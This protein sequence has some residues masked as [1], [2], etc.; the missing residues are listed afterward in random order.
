MSPKELLIDRIS[1]QMMKKTLKIQIVREREFKVLQ[2]SVRCWQ[3]L[4]L[5]LLIAAPSFSLLPAPIFFNSSK[6]IPSCS[7]QPQKR[8][9][10]E[11]QRV[12]HSNVDLVWTG[13]ELC[14]ISLYLH[15][16]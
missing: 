16:F 14:H 2:T 10:G 6:I 4:T 12:G 7:L 3:L 5:S 8:Y 13:S 1:G 15:G 9:L 11:E